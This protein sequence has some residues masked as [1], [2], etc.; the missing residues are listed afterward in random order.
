MN[1]PNISTPCSDNVVKKPKLN[2]SNRIGE[3]GK[4]FMHTLC[5]RFMIQ[6]Q[7]TFSFMVP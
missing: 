4:Y 3:I 7:F 5:I 6:F 2:A 1:T